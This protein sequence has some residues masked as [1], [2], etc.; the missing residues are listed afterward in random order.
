MADRWCLEKNGRE[1][2]S[3]THTSKWINLTWHGIGS[4]NADNRQASE[5]HVSDVICKG[6]KKGGR[7]RIPSQSGML[8]QNQMCDRPLNRSFAGMED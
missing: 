7:G 8:I 1:V 3:V 2:L 6:C 5:D 4:G